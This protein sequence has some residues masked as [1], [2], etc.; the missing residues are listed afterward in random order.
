MDAAFFHLYL[1]CGSKGNW[2]KSE[3]ES[4][5]EH[6]ELVDAFRCPRD[7]VKYILESFDRKTEREKLEWRMMKK[8]ILANY[9]ALGKMIALAAQLRGA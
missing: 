8:D 9:D 5:N 4:A 1:P 3:N 7:A 6:A 2:L